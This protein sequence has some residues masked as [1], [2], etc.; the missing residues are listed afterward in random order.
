[1]VV[2]YCAATIKRLTI[3]HCSVVYV[4]QCGHL[5]VFVELIQR[6]FFF[7]FLIYSF[8]VFICACVFSL[9]AG[10]IFRSSSCMSYICIK[11]LSWRGRS[12]KQQKC[13][14]QK[15]M[16]PFRSKSS[17]KWKKQAVWKNVWCGVAIVPLK[18]KSV[19]L[20]LKNLLH[21]VQI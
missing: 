5:E 6:F 21:L 9:L 11:L 16:L 19:C 10:V 4:L 1:M 2:L 17:F 7:F 12:L 14:L 18:W 8:V 15:Q 20:I 3:L 13:H